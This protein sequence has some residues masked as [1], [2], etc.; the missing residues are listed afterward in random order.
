MRPAPGR[1]VLLVAAACALS[2]TPAPASA[3][4][5]AAAS[6]ERCAVRLRQLDKCGKKQRD[7]FNNSFQRIAT[8]A[9]E[10]CGVVY[11]RNWKVGSTTLTNGMEAGCNVTAAAP[12]KL[13]S[14]SLDAH[15]GW[16][17]DRYTLFTFVREPIARFVSGY[18]FILGKNRPPDILERWTPSGEGCRA[19]LAGAGRGRATAPV[20]DRLAVLRCFLDDLEAIS[21]FA[22][23][24]SGP[25][26]N[27]L[28]DMHVKPQSYALQDGCGNPIDFD[29]IGRVERM[30]SE[31]R[32][33]EAIT[34]HKFQVTG[35][36]G[37]ADA[38][39]VAN[40][41]V[42]AKSVNRSFAVSGSELP[43]DVVQQ[44]C[45]LYRKDFE[46]LRDFYPLPEVCVAG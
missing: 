15:Q 5:L 43:D 32:R 4:A 42:A 17:L 33:L 29:F 21:A 9:Q 14:I 35:D 1:A 26:S 31:L 12:S 19:V 10:S 44:V 13:V 6:P 18:N 37:E 23:A 24:P 46:L 22:C 30:T 39:P 20:A 2:Q 34:G 25:A 11:R 3:S 45:A 16:Y 28:T 27:A 7:N 8:R 40:H 36:E 38:V 41:N